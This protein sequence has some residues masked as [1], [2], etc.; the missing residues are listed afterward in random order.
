MHLILESIGFKCNTTQK[1]ELEEFDMKK[2]TV[3]IK[4]EG[5]SVDDTST[6]REHE[7]GNFRTIK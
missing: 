4:E 7:E 5:S 6:R 1:I 2:E 3:S